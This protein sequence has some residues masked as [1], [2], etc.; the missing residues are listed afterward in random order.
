M[1]F[2]Y[3]IPLSLHTLVSQSINRPSGLPGLITPIRPCGCPHQ[4]IVPSSGPTPSL[5]MHSSLHQPPNPQR[6][7]AKVPALATPSGTPIADL[8]T[9]HAAYS[10]TLA[11]A[12][13]C[14]GPALQNINTTS[15]SRDPGACC[16][17]LGSRRRI[18][19]LFASAQFLPS[20]FNDIPLARL[21]AVADSLVPSALTIPDHP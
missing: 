1:L 17:R 9:A 4:P 8:G 7:L 11:S 19:R 10:P 3:S 6:P 21:C 16:V 18:C 2:I 5:D 14:F 13:C 20:P 15:P 12:P